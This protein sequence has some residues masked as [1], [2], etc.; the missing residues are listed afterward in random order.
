MADYLRLVFPQW[1]G[2][3][4][5]TDLYDGALAIRDAFLP[6][7][8]YEQ[9]DVSLDTGLCADHGIWAY[10]A[11]LAQ[12]KRAVDCI[13]RVRP[14]KIFTIGGCCGVEIAPVSY[15]NQLYDR[16]LT[17]IWFD[18][19]GDLNTP[20]SSPSTYFHGMPLRT[21]LG[22][23]DEDI[24]GQCVSQLVPEQVV[25]AGCRELDPEEEEY[26]NRHHV[27]RLGVNLD[28]L[29]EA[30][31]AMGPNLYIH[32]DL[33]VLDPVCFPPVMCPVKG[34]ITMENL[35]KTLRALKNE[36]NIVGFS[37]TEYAPGNGVDAEQ[38][39]D[40]IEWGCCL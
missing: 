2:A 9:I 22:E 19:H 39:R 21:L 12:L 13:A 4:L 35:T 32:L 3:G 38:L 15:L 17:V 16:D 34:G 10:A 24:L 23:G 37:V 6:V 14:G 7:G 33:D 31:N 5:G 1:Q 36:Y 40:I 18:A 28:P 25:L 8:S 11:I 29:M 27:Q 26:V 30:V 20:E